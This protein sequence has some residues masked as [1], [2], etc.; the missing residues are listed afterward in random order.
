ME[1]LK[2]DQSVMS[3]APK[4]CIFCGKTGV[5]KEHVWPAWLMPYLPSGAVN[6]ESLNEIRHRTH[7][8]QEIKKHSGSPH[9]GR[10]RIVCGECN[11]GWMS[12][13]QNE[14]KPILLPM[15]LGETTTL[16]RKQLETLGA[17]VTMFSMVAEFK[18]D[19]VRRIAIS[20][21]Q[22]GRF[23]EHRKPPPEFKIWIGSYDRQL[24]KGVYFHNVLPVGDVPKTADGYPLPNTQTTSMTAGK[25][26]AHLISST[27]RGIVRKQRISTAPVL[28]LWPIENSL[29]DWPPRS[30]NDDEVEGISMAFIRGAERRA[31]LESK[32]S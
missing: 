22:R 32:L 21:E 28:Q 13:L 14:T 6:H 15:V 26:Y 3:K 9:S 23:M 27:Q 7:V 25:F 8:E 10:L 1:L 16:N 4:H 20:A 24:L 29:I 30:L 19:D 31:G 11:N 17:W 18:S 12:R 2:Q 5:T